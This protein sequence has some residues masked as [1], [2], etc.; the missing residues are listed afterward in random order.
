M[1]HFIIAVT[2]LGLSFGAAPLRAADGPAEKTIT[3]TFTVE[4]GGELDVDADQGD[5]EILTGN[6]DTVEVVV[7]RDV[8]HVT[9]AGLEKALKRHKVTITQ[10]GKVVRVVATTTKASHGLFSSAQPNLDVH[11]KVTV[12]RRFDA[13]L[14]TAGGNIRVTDLNGTV[15]ARTSGGDLNFKQVQGPVE[16]HTSGGNVRALG[17]ADKLTI[18]TSG[19]NIVIKDFTG[20][21]ASA[22][23]SGGNIDVANCAGR[24]TVK[25]SG[26]N[27]SIDGFAGASA[28]ADT[29][30]GS[31][32]VNLTKAPTGD[33][34][35]STSGGN[36]TARLPADAALNLHAMTEGGTVDSKLP[37]TVE[38]K[39]KDGTLEGKINGGGPNLALKTSGGNISVLKL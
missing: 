13:T 11:I 37:V 7:E 38:G 28:Y 24:L 15:D 36:V 8:P 29:S 30:G 14:N 39:Q 9:E 20:A 26:G 35:F 31:I 21:A 12:P 6:Q 23:T 19:G 17:C 32:Q 18:Q 2:C 25:T 4:S 16:G 34:W 27:I 5:I 1:K 3:K 33:C 10:E 22:D